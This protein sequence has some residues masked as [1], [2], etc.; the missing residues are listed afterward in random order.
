MRNFVIYIAPFPHKNAL[1]TTTGLVNEM[2]AFGEPK[3]E[4]LLKKSPEV[5]GTCNV[6]RLSLNCL[7]ICLRRDSRRNS[8]YFLDPLRET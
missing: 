1:L 8:I 5:C 7:F 3:T 2:S 4:K 6:P